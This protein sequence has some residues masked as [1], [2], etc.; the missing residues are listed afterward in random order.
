MVAAELLARKPLASGDSL[1]L[2]E[3]KPGTPVSS[4]GEFERSAPGTP[5]VLGTASL[6]TLASILRESDFVPTHL[7]LTDSHFR[8]EPDGAAEV[9]EVALEKLRYE[10][11][12]DVLDFFRN[13][14]RGFYVTA[15]ELRSRLGGRVTIR[16]SGWI[17]VHRESLLSVAKRALLASTK[18]AGIW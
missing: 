15:V 6:L 3:P 11:I 16:R 1:Q 4:Y 9:Q 12:D 2:L 8:I 13:Q 18:R 14:G 17:T 10:S 5:V 7:E